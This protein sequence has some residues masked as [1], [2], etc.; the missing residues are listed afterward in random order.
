MSAV[1]DLH[2]VGTHPVLSGAA[3]VHGVLDRMHA[4]A[5]QPLVSGEHA[6][7]VAE[8]DR[9][10]RRIEALKLKVVVAAEKAGTA[11]DA[12]FTD[13]TAWIARTTTVSRP[14]AARDVALATELDS[15][16]DATAEALDAG[17]VSPGHAAVIVNATGQLPDGVSDEQRQLVE[18]HLVEKAGRFSPDQL[19]RIARR[20]I[21]AVEPDQSVVDA[22]ENELIRTE[23]Q[24]AEAK[25]SFAMHDNGD[26]TSTGHFTVPDLAA[27]ILAKILDTITAP[28][29]MRDSSTRPP[30]RSDAGPVVRLAAS[31]R[32]RVRRTPRAPPAALPKTQQPRR[33]K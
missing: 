22:H 20:A 11:K 21:E 33:H 12:G 9:A 27:A 7:V 16:H 26:G 30:E 1:L 2:P 3:E 19:R 8:L 31:P 4:G 24:A 6:L 5:A 10:T 28:R 13:T 14:D 25:C 18:A 17:L 29:R 23:E 32:A 15:G